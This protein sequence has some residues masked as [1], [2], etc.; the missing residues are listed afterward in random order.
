GGSSTGIELNNTGSNGGLT[1]RGTGAAGTGGTIQNKTIGISLTNTQA[2][3][4][5]WMQL[6]GFSDYAIRG[7]NVVGFTL[8][9]SVIN[10]VNGNSA[11]DDEGSVRFTNLTGSA[12]I[13]GTS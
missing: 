1:V 7:T 3:S 12:S 11:A 5:S 9:N 4:F 8:V 6:N 10:G 13:S 2:P